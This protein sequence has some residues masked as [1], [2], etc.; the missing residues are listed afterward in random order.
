MATIDLGKIKQVFRGTYDNS[1][2]Y[3]PDDL[4]TFT[5]TGITSTYI[6][7]TAS[8]GNNPSSGGTAHANWAYIAKGVVDPVPSQSGQSGKFLTTDGSS[9]SFGAITQAVKKIYSRRDGARHSVNNQVQNNSYTSMWNWTNMEQ[10][11][12]P[13][14]NTSQFHIT[15]SLNISHYGS[16]EGYVTITYQHSGLSGETAVVSNSQT[17][18]RRTHRGNLGNDTS[19]TMMGPVPL[20]LIV[21]PATTN[22]V[23]FQIRLAT[24]ASGYPWSVN[25]DQANTT[26]TSDGGGVLS[27]WTIT[28]ID[29]GQVTLNQTDVTLDV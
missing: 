7:T 14:S 17:N 16:Y 28:E 11:I 20:D 8:T 18:F 22:A 21:A 26:N 12:T 13:Q 5:D 1:T 6:C 10:A 2:A 19:S 29:G 25:R 4:V 9:L 3:V 15:G 23:T 27:S 24:S